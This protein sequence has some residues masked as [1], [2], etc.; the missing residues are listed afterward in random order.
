MGGGFNLG[1][2]RIHIKSDNTIHILYIKY[3]NIVVSIV[4]FIDAVKFCTN[5]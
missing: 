5:A 4:N 3:T 1:N 2:N